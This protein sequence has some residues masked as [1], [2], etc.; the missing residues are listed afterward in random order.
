MWEDRNALGKS[1]IHLVCLNS[2]LCLGVIGT[3][4]PRVCRMAAA[5]CKIGGHRKNKLFLG[6][7][8]TYCIPAK[9]QRLMAHPAAFKFPLLDKSKKM[10]TVHKIVEEHGPETALITCNWESYIPPALM[11]FDLQE[12]GLGRK[13]IP[14]EKSDDSKDGEESRG[15]LSLHN[16]PSLMSWDAPFEA[17]E[18]VSFEEESGREKVV[19]ELRKLAD[20][21]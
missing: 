10:P 4:K 16:I 9:K 18:Q 19:E 15:D 20:G 11:E 8:A 6:S 13:C 7:N 14:E 2:A 21:L 5:L 17:S 1:E 3:D 12:R